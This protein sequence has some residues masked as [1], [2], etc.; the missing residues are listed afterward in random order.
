[1]LPCDLK[2]SFPRS[3]WAVGLSTGLGLENMLLCEYMMAPTRRIERDCLT[4]P[5]TVR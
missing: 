1:M 5:Q 2:Q 4:M 3:G